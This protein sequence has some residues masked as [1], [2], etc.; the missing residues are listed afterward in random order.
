VLQCDFFGVL[1]DLA[2]LGV[3]MPAADAGVVLF[4]VVGGQAGTAKS[5]QRETA[6]AVAKNRM[7]SLM[8][9]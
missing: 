7:I 5:C 8:P 4:M 9:P 1:V 2:N 3:V 6:T